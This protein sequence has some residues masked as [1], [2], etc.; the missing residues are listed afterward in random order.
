MKL[1]SVVTGYETPALK[2]TV[3]AASVAPIFI[4]IC[5]TPQKQPHEKGGKPARTYK[6]TCL[7]S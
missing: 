3:E 2:T 6:K 5:Q 4:H 1:R 7:V